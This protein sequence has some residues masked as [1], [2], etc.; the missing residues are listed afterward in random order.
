MCVCVENVSRGKALEPQHPK[1]KNRRVCVG[2]PCEQVFAGL[3]FHP[4]V[5]L[6]HS[7]AQHVAAK[8][9]QAAAAAANGAGY[10]LAATNIT[11]LLQVWM[12]LCV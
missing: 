7:A 5:N 12:C 1:N 3:R 6:L 11:A 8:L 10:R 9:Q 4:G 2:S